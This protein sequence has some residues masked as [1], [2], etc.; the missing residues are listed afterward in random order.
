MLDYEL[1]KDVIGRLLFLNHVLTAV[2]LSIMLDMEVTF[3]C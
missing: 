1:I 2:S 3:L